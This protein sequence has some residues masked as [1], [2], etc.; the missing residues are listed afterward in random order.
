MN[1]PPSST[2][3]DR[4]SNSLNNV[5]K[6][7]SSSLNRNSNSCKRVIAER[8][9]G[10]LKSARRIRCSRFIMLRIYKK[11]CIFPTATVLTTMTTPT[12]PYTTKTCPWTKWQILPVKNAALAKQKSST[13]NKS[14]NNSNNNPM[15]RSNNSVNTAI[16]KYNPSKRH[17]TKKYRKLNL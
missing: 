3:S 2:T 17:S 15:N 4:N 7:S 1:T 10:F 14:C 11:T 16:N 12:S 9:V 13:K 5:S 8:S 6:P